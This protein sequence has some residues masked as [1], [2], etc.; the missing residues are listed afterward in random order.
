MGM[1]KNNKNCCFS[2]AGW[3]VKYKTQARDFGY[4]NGVKATTNWGRGYL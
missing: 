4:L 3:C 1:S 2:R